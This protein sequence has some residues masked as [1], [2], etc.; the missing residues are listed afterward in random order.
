MRKILRGNVAGWMSQS[1]AVLETG[2]LKVEPFFFGPEDRQLY[3]VYHSP[4]S[5]PARHTAVL[6]LYPLGQEYM[7]IHRSYRWLADRLAKLG[8]PVL[9]FD[10]SGQGNSAG[11]GPD[12]N[13]WLDETHRAATELKAISGLDRLIVIGCRLG[14]II[15]TQLAAQVTVERLVL[16]EPRST[17]RVFIDEM[18]TLLTDGDWPLANFRAP[19]GTLHFNGFAFPQAFVA[20]LEQLALSSEGLRH[21][22]DVLALT[23][24]QNLD[25]VQV[26]PNV[27][28]DTT[29]TRAFEP[30]PTDWNRVDG[31]GGLFLPQRILHVICGWLEQSAS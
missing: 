30:G 25:L 13:S 3:G 26:V 2:L 7:R 11:D 17:G 28:P 21:T 24:D 16:W 29:I 4:L 22:G 6:L 19:D 1:G 10:Y 14:A 9:R 18:N 5:T 27:G 8:F 15:A 20:A 12:I 31:I 23:S